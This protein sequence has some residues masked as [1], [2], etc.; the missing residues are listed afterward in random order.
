M[1]EDPGA[2]IPEGDLPEEER[3]KLEASRNV[4]AEVDHMK[5]CASPQAV[6]KMRNDPRV[7]GVLFYPEGQAPECPQGGLDSGT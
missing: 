5:V 4:R 1:K 6:K 2:E 3:R 7:L